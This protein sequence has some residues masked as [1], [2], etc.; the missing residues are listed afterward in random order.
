MKKII[1]STLYP[2]LLIAQIYL[3]AKHFIYRNMPDHLVNRGDKR[4]NV[5]KL[6][7]NRSTLSSAVYIEKNLINAMCNTP[8]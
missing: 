5:Y 6:L 7:W 1:K 8:I 2:I 3:S 4:K